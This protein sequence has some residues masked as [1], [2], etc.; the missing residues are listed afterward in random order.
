MGTW[1]YGYMGLCAYGQMGLWA[2]GHVAICVCD[3][4]AMWPYGI[5]YIGV[6]ERFLYVGVLTKN[7]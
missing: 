7:P 6:Q 3:H 1:T 4:M 5:V 2:N